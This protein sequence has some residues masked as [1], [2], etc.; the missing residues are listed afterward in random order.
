[1]DA[2]RSGRPG[3]Y[4]RTDSELQKTQSGRPSPR[5]E[6]RSCDR[7]CAQSLAWGGAASQVGFPVGGSA[8]PAG[9]RDHGICSVPR[10]WICGN[11]GKVAREAA[12]PSQTAVWVGSEKDLEEATPDDLRLTNGDGELD[13]KT[14]A[15]LRRLM[16][17]RP[18]S[19]RLGPANG[20][21]GTKPPRRRSSATRRSAR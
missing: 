2:E 1:M 14:V 3:A 17:L 8:L 21:R 16:R 18:R 15:G 10:E 4:P 6:R 9:G 5:C 19:G 20:E 13:T 7:S 12:P 11:G